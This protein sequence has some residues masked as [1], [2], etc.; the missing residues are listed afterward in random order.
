VCAR[1]TI[2]YHARAS[3]V[4]LIL[5]DDV[6]EEAFTWVTALPVHAIGLDFCGV[7]G[8]AHGNLTTQLINKYGFPSDKRLGAGVIDGRSVWADDG[9]AVRIVAALRARLGPQQAIC[10]QVTF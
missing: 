9:T 5:Q 4:H 2:F 3:F 6:P 10:V 1:S 7:P 8:A